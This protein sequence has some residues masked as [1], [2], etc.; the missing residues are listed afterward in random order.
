MT[1]V[2]ISLTMA[3]ISQCTQ[4]LDHRVVRFKHRELLFNN[5]I[6]IKLRGKRL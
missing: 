6:S 3:I 1:D 4:I 5:Y 2:L